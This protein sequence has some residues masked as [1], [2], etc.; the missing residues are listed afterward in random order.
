MENRVQLLNIKVDIASTED[1]V[2]LTKRYIEDESSRVVYF[3]NSETILLLQDNEQWNALLEESELILPGNASVNTGVDEVLG[4]K[5]DPFFY[6][7]FFDAVWDAA[8]E[9]GQEL[10]LVAENQEKFVSIQEHIHGKRP[11]LALSG[12]FLTEQEETL[13]HIVNEI[14][15][16]AP[17]VLILALD[18]KRQMELLEQ[19]RTQINAGLFLFIGNILYHHAVVE[20]EVPEQIKKLKIEGIYRWFKGGGKIKAFFNNLKMKFK[21]KFEK[22]EESDV[23]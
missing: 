11:F 23:S 10:F 20:S 4:Y 1:A 3:A 7:S 15:S 8:V 2:D 9:T 21:L 19:F 18:E 22:K 17:D 16:V 6:E 12:M 13:G 14:N 5:R